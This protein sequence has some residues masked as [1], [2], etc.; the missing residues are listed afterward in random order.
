MGFAK[1]FEE[2]ECWQKARFLTKEIYRIARQEPLAKDFGLRGQI[3]RA[4]VSIMSNIAEGHG[5]RSERQFEHYLGIARTSGSEVQS[6]LYVLLDT[7]YIS[8]E[9]F[10]SLYL[11]TEEIILMIAGLQRYLRGKR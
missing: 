9:L 8:E 10:D 6:L 3:Q 4:S 5:C 2:L 11:K 1:R 7:E